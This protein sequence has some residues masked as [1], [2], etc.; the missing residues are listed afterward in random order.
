VRPGVGDPETIDAVIGYS[1]LLISGLPRPQKQT[2]PDPEGQE[3]VIVGVSARGETSFC[4]RDWQG[5]L[6][7]QVQ[8]PL[9]DIA[10]QVALGRQNSRN[11]VQTGQ[12]HTQ[13]VQTVAAQDVCSC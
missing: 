8:I 4:E 1:P 2:V 6:I 7:E 10:Q 9:H 3:L 11:L 5:Q 13:K 12:Q